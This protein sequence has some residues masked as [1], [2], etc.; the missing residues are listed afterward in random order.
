MQ[1]NFK[2]KTV[3]EL[4]K[5]TEGSMLEAGY[6]GDYLGKIKCVWNRLMDYSTFDNT[7]Y[8]TVE[9]GLEFLEQAYAIPKD[10]GYAKLKT[11]DRI[12]K[13][14][15]QF[16]LNCQDY[17]NFK[18]PKLTSVLRV[19]PKHEDVILVFLEKRKSTN[20]AFSTIDRDIRF[21][22]KFS[23]FLIQS[24]ITEFQKISRVLV[25][26]FMEKVS[27]TCKHPT[28]LG[29]S[30]SLKIFLKFLYHE[31]FISENLEFFVPRVKSV[32]H[33]IV[34]SAFSKDDIQRMLKSVD[35]SSPIGKRN[36]AILIIASW[37]GIRASDICSLTFKNINWDACTV[38]FV[39]QKTKVPTTL[40]I[41]D[42][43]GGAIIEY[44]KYGRM[45]SDEPFIFLRHIS[46]YCKMLPSSLHS[47]VKKQMLCAG[48]KI[49]DGKRHGPHSLRHSLAGALL[50][51][52][53]PLPV[54]TEILSHADGN[55]T[56]GYLKI[57]IRHLRDRSLGV[58]IWHP[59]W[60]GG[61]GR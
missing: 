61:T 43:I 42:E 14:A 4:I 41:S 52:E 23:T 9:I 51:N 19:S 17:E 25:T 35:R 15:V 13:R 56:M 31:K 16:L 21:L 53:T 39:Q 8:L 40:P 32:P 36:Y 12:K 33:E 1:Q 59:A 49:P 60:I 10:T 58:P 27:I 37:L 34:P 24:G 47:I 30:N 29:I 2:Q 22:N 50:D 38:E 45:R 48:V 11:S 54:I 26:N 7:E 44:I 6:S 5:L 28:L 46:P 20:L 55:T 3:M 18:A 57:D